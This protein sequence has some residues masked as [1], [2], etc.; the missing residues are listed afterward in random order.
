MFGKGFFKAGFNGWYQGIL[1]PMVIGRPGKMTLGMA[2]AGMS[3]GS[4]RAAM[5][6]DKSTATITLGME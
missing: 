3:L 6:L 5:T 2:R 4:S 1:E